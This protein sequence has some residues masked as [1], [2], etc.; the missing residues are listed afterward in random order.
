VLGGATSLFVFVVLRLLPG[1]PILTRL[2][3]QSSVDPETVARLR[4]EAGLDDPIYKQYLDWLGG[5]V[6][7]DLGQSY[8]SQYDVTA[9][10]GSRLGPTL[11][12]TVV[13]VLLTV[14]IAVPLAIASTLKPGGLADRIIVATTS[15]G[16]AMPQ[17]LLGVVLILVFSLQLGWFPARGFVSLAEDP[18]KNLQH[19]AL[20]AVTLALVS[21]PILVR[22]LRASMFE[23]LQSSWVR[24]AEGKGVP[25]DKVV[26]THVLRNALIPALTVLGLTVGHTLGGAVI[27]EYVFGFSGLGSLAVESVSKRDYAVLQSVVVLISALFIFT[28]C[29]V[30]ILYGV[31]D[32]RLRVRSGRG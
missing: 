12:L 18:L 24:T 31:L 10:I 2:G 7:G 14:L 17:F 5:A 9:M 25:H 28:S 26:T 16:M 30:D 4:A 13:A 21:A 19:I 23:G 1:D 11:E 32:P 6:R 20:P 29:A 22:F 3:E 8:F 15:V 27:V